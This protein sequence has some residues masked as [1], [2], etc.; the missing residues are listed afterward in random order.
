MIC[1]R[2]TLLNSCRNSAGDGSLPRSSA[3]STSRTSRNTLCCPMVPAA[4]C[5]P[6]RTTVANTVL[7]QLQEGAR[8][9]RQ[10]I[11]ALRL[12]TLPAPCT[13]TFQRKLSQ[14]RQHLPTGH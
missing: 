10:P 4:C 9:Q 8:L 3:R 1:Y 14:P 11:V 12:H 2:P 7:V 13:D 5:R 6:V